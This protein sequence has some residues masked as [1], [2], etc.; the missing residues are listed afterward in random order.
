MTAPSLNL[1]GVPKDDDPGVVNGLHTSMSAHQQLAMQ[2]RLASEDAP[3]K[4]ADPGQWSTSTIGVP[5]P[6][7]KGL[8]AFEPN[9]VLFDAYG[10]A[11]AQSDQSK[12]VA[13]AEQAQQIKVAGGLQLG[14][15]AVVGDASGKVGA[16]VQAA[17]SLA[18]R[19]VPYV[20][21]GTSSNGV[22]CSGL[23][24]YAAKAAGLNLPRLRAKDLGQMGQEVTVAQAQPGDIVYYDEAGD[25]DHVGIYLGN[26]KMVQAP[27]SGE[28]VKISNIGTPTSIRRLFTDNS[29]TPV[30]GPGGTRSFAYNGQAYQPWVIAPQTML[31]AYAGTGRTRAQ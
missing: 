23:I 30:A 13:Q 19:N 11:K 7:G 10:S 4:I 1:S 16:M 18:K 29:I 12:A 24:Y 5:N 14:S 31:T 17:L 8:A 2:M 22:D 25:T 26:G 3:D 15:G 27:Q 9:C 6:Y 21:G 28:T 20:W